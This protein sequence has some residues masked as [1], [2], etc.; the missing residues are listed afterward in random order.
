MKKTFVILSL[1]DGIS[2]GQ[3]VIDG[4][5]PKGWKKLYY[6]SEIE[7]SAIKVTM[8]H[9][10][11]TKQLGNVVNIEKN[12]I[13]ESVNLLIGGS[14]CTDFSNNGKKKGMITKDGIEIVSLEQYLE[15]KKNKVEF[16]GESYLFWEF[17]R[18][19]KIIK[20]KYF[21]LENVRIPKTMKKWQDII[22]KELGGVDPIPINSSLVSA[23]NRERLYWTNIPNVS[24]PDDENIKLSDIIPGALGCGERGTYNKE[25]G[26]WNIKKLTVRNDNKSNCIV[27]NVSGTQQI[28]FKYIKNPTSSQVKQLKKDNIIR[29]LTADEAEK[30]QTLPLGYTKIDGITDIQRYKMIGNGWTPKIIF[31]IFKEIPELV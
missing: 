30:I 8:H 27:T 23:Q 14:P 3:I 22:S 7:Q 31:H 1:F 18:I 25:T 10:P 2:S 26:R 4:I 5:I 24:I 17:I 21:L 9:F 20:P 12:M 6:A 11:D 15:L 16:Y 19:W 13:P 28:T 29:N